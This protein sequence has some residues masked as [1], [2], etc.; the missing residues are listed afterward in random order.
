MK[1]FILGCLFFALFM[2]FLYICSVL[3][4]LEKK[5]LEIAE[6]TEKEVNKLYQK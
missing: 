1:L 6:I 2:F 4:K 5:V 3:I